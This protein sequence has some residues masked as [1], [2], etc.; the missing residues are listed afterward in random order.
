[1]SVSEFRDL[2]SAV[3]DKISSVKSARSGEKDRELCGL[4]DWLRELREA[5]WP[6]RLPDADR[7]KAMRVWD[8]ANDMIARA[9]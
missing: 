2:V 5:Q 1:M 6:K 3:S 7:A 8:S 4:Q 9:V